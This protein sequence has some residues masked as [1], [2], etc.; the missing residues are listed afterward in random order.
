MNGV[1]TPIEVRNYQG[2]DK[3]LKVDGFLKWINNPND[4]LPIF[5][6]GEIDNL[7]HVICIK[8]SETIISNLS[9]RTMPW[10]DGFT[11]DFYETFKEV[12]ITIFESISPE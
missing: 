6:Q 3:N 1:N 4:K 2:G 12:V 7:N 11:A 9:K 5:M 8:E 10:S